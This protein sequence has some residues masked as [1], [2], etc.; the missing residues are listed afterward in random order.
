MLYDPLVFLPMHLGLALPMSRIVQPA[1][2]FPALPFFSLFYFAQYLIEH[3]TDS[4]PTLAKYNAALVMVALATGP[5]FFYQAYKATTSKI[6]VILGFLSFLG[7]TGVSKGKEWG[8]PKDTPA[9]QIAALK[10]PFYND[11][12]LGL[13]IA[14]VIILVGVSFTCPDSKLKKA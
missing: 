13:H 12:H 14:F 2:P 3:Y 8:F 6:I 11:C 7:I 9:E 4:F 5:L 1:M 10:D